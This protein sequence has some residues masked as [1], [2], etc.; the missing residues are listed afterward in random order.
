[1][2]VDSDKGLQENRRDPRVSQK[3]AQE[4]FYTEGSQE[5]IPMQQMPPGGPPQM[6][7]HSLSQGHSRHHG[8]PYYKPNGSNAP[9]HFDPQSNVSHGHGVQDQYAQHDQ[10]APGYN[11][12]P[13]AQV[14][15]RD[16]NTPSKRYITPS[17]ASIIAKRVLTIAVL[18]FNETLN[19]LQY[20]DWKGTI[21]LPSVFGQIGKK[22]KTDVIECSADAPFLPSLYGLFCGV[23][24]VYAVFQ[25]INI[26]GETVLEYHRRKSGNKYEDTGSSQSELSQNNAQPG[27]LHQDRSQE[28]PETDDGDPERQDEEEQ[29]SIRQRC[30]SIFYGFQL[31]HGWV[32]TVAA[33]VVEDL[34][35]II[36]M[37]FSSYYCTVS[38]E[39][40]V[41]VL[42]WLVVKELK[43]VFRKAFCKHKYTACACDCGD[44]FKGCCTYT[45]HCCCVVLICRLCPGPEERCFEKRPVDCKCPDCKCPTFKC[46]ECKC[47]F[48][49]NSI[50]DR[51]CKAFG[52]KD[53]DPEWVT[54]LLP[55]LKFLTGVGWFAI[56][57][58]QILGLSDAFHAS[59]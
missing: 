27:P 48:N 31:L 19:W 43:N 1:M 6:Q 10:V 21:D 57:V 33:M 5:A 11:H 35:Q 39:N 12:A 23:A 9:G 4:V 38:L 52:P 46:P 15:I 44:C 37:A 40:A 42:I 50:C 54:K 8:H 59:N 29:K 24:T 32:E 51:L 18:I 45:C 14:I 13:H 28:Q 58:L 3:H 22:G 17:I 16:A 36:V 41:F 20:C 26:T 7:D 2:E 49:C 53:I 47:D 55:K 56:V 30:V 25:I 34:P